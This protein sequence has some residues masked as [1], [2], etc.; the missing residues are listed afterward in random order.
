ME[1]LEAFGLPPTFPEF[2]MPD[3]AAQFVRDTHKGMSKTA[4]LKLA[5]DR[6]FRP[7]WKSLPHIGA[8]V[9]GLGLTVDGM[10][11]PFMVRMRSNAKLRGRAP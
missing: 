5:K 3:K 1:R 11:V 9:Y 6:G 10:C 4:L 7:L 8:A 2:M